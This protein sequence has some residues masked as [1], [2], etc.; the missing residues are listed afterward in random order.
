MQWYITLQ[1]AQMEAQV[2]GHSIR[3]L[4]I[5]H[6]ALCLF[7]CPPPPPPPPPLKGYAKIG[8]GEGGKLGVL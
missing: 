8:E 3:H 1:A 2:K 5:S 6:N 7:P 4:H